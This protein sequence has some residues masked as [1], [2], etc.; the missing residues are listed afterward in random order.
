MWY[1]SIMSWLLRSP[2]HGMLD[3]GTMLVTVTGRRS[4][5]EYSTPVNYLRDG[6]MLWVT[7]TRSRTWWRN[8]IGGAP[9]HVLLAGQDLKAHG[10]AI[11]DEQAVTESLVSYF[12]KAPQVAKYYKVSFDAA[13]QPSR[14]DC[15]RAAKDRV[16][17]RI[18]LV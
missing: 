18:D 13:G 16:V 4:G 15:A 9:L 6:S 10:E 8:L 1:N 12:Q 11:I 14:E 2:L 3:K 7:S 5:K 17:I